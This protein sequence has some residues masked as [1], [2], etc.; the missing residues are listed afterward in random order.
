MPMQLNPRTRAILFLVLR[1]AVFAGVSWLAVKWLVLQQVKEEEFELVQEAGLGIRFRSPGA[2]SEVKS[3]EMFG[4]KV[5]SITTQRQEVRRGRSDH[6][7]QGRGVVW[8]R[9]GEEFYPRVMANIYSTEGTN[10]ID[11]SVMPDNAAAEWRFQVEQ[12]V[13][14]RYKVGP[15]G[16]R[17][18]PE[19]VVFKSPVITEG[20]PRPDVV[21]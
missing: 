19:Y 10:F 17:T 9:E 5:A 1:L 20:A 16:F 4:A 3:F 21:R 11:Y 14:R 13:S 15:F 6:R 2:K 8:V 12:R 7:K 18:K